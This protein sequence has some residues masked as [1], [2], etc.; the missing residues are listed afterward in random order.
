ML[1]Q[2]QA[3]AL[4]ALS[5]PAML[6]RP[7]QL[8]S[9]R[10]SCTLAMLAPQCT[11]HH[12]S[13]LHLTAVLNTPRSSVTNTSQSATNMPVTA[14]CTPCCRLLVLCEAALAA[15]LSSAA[16]EDPEEAA[17]LAPTLLAVADEQGLQ[18]LRGAALAYCVEHYAD[19]SASRAWGHLGP[20]QVGLVAREAAGQ[21]KRVKALLS[22]LSEN[23]SFTLPSPRWF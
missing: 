16:E 22:E 23:S 7:L 13:T 17:E 12:T 18:Q 4:Q 15:E 8:T 11:K 14:Y 10:M 2:P 1:C 21:L 9:R 6:K 20:G 5:T 3:V 19:V